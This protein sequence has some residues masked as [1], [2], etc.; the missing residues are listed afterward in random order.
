M[1]SFFKMRK[2]VLRKDVELKHEYIKIWK[3]KM[4]FE[5]FWYFV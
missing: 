3:N 2:N 5:K 1:F 4:S